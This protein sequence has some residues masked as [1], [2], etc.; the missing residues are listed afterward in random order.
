[1]QSMKKEKVKKLIYCFLVSFFIIS[2]ASAQK[3]RIA[4]V[5]NSITAGAKLNDPPKESYPAQL[6]RLLGDQYD[7]FNFGVSGK[8]VVAAN[9]Y[10]ATST[11]KE[12][13]LSHPDIVHSHDR[14]FQQAFPILPA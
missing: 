6:Q 8:T 13:L 11:F 7:V 1:M 2:S 12:A 4:C 3:I 14:F 5:G 10:A 9:G